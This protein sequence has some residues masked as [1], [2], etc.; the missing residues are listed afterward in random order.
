MKTI[1]HS[2]QRLFNDLDRFAL[3]SAKTDLKQLNF[4]QHEFYP[5]RTAVFLLISPKY[6]YA[7]TEEA[8]AFIFNK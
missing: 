4:T 5:D 6:Q 2:I 7:N 3:L 8:F 1:L